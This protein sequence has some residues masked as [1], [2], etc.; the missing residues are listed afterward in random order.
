MAGRLAPH[1]GRSEPQQRAL[2]Y[3]HGLLSSV[4]RKTIWQRAGASGDAIPYG[5][6]YL[7]GRVDWEADTVRD[8]LRHYLMQ[9]LR[10]LCMR[11]RRSFVRIIL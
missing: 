4:E 11:Y 9:H 8:E 7:L 6:Q 5:F 10:T 1:F 3:V 2:V